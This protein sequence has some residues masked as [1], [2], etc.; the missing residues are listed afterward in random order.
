MKLAANAYAIGPSLYDFE[1]DEWEKRKSDVT[2]G[3]RLLKIIL[4]CGA[5]FHT[6]TAIKQR[7]LR[8]SAKS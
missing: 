3:T 7:R 1:R 8:R 4:N 2:H 6:A 5:G